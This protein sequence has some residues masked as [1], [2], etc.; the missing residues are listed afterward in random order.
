LRLTKKPEIWWVQVQ[1]IKKQNNHSSSVSTEDVMKAD[2][3]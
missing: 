2:D 3:S 1:S